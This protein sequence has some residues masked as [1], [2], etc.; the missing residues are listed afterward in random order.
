MVAQ[1][2]TPAVARA[3]WE[4]VAESV[5]LIHSE[6]VEI[7]LNQMQKSN[8][9]HFINEC[10]ETLPDRF[11]VHLIVQLVTLVKKVV[12]ISKISSKSVTGEILKR[13]KI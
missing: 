3:I 1:I 9:Q 2:S 13:R 11:N 7:L 8:R 6:D 4:S 10:F 5:F 12:N